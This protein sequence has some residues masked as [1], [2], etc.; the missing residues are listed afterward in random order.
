MINHFRDRMP[1]PLVG[2]GHSMGG[3]NIACV[4]LIHPRLFTSVILIDP[5]IQR[6][7]T[8]LGHFAPALA[9]TFRRDVWPSRHAAAENF[10]RNRFYQRWDPRVLELWI[11]HGLRELPTKLYPRESSDE[12]SPL[13]GGSTFEESS[14]AKNR[15]S[16]SRE[17]P[18]TLTT[19]K[20]QEVLT[21]LRANHPPKGIPLSQHKSNPRTHRDVPMMNPMKPYYRPEPL[22]TFGQL[23]FLRP[24]CLYIFAETSPL[25][26]PE[27]RKDKMEVTGTGVGG[28]GG[29]LEGAVEDV[30]VGDG[31]GHFLPFE[32]PLVTSKHMVAWLQKQATRFET[33]EA[34]EKC[35]WAGVEARKKAMWEEDRPEWMKAKL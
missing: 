20:H 32:R 1:R 22:L 6:Y 35:E 11:R 18:V 26:S 9:S 21:F 13:A 19:T 28:S 30:V 4:A 24:H 17:K 31:A 12:K 2:I 3:H 7:V 10:R 16:S 5:V 25:S 23:P 15:S 29:W 14:E 34:E 27:M 8:A 33:E